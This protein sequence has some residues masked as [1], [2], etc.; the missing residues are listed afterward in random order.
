MIDKAAILIKKAALEFEKVTNPIFAEYDLTASQY[1]IL[2]FLYASKSRSARLV[3]LEKE[4]S[5][6]HPTAIGLVN[7]LEG[8]GFVAR[9]TNPDSAR[10]KLIVLTEKADSMQEELLKLGDAVEDKLTER[11]NSEERAQLIALLQKLLSCN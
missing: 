6:T 11:L 2:K 9:T 10:G 7:T 1:K 3:D 4:Y 8:K 5:M